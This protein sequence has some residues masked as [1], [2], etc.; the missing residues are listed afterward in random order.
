MEADDHVYLYND[1][2]EIRAMLRDTGWRVVQDLPN[3]L[4][5]SDDWDPLPVNYSAVLARADG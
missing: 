2:E 5:G 3:V 1:V 4:P